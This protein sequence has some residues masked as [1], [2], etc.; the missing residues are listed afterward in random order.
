MPDQ[1]FCYIRKRWI[2]ATPEEKIRQF[3]IK[4]MVEKLQY[5]PNYFIMEKGLNQMP[6]LDK[7]CLNSL[8][9]RRIDLI[10]LAKNLHPQYPLYPLLLIECKAIKITQKAIRQV[11]GYNHFLGACFVAVINQ[12]ET[13]L[14]SSRFEANLKGEHLQEPSFP[15][16][17]TLLQKAKAIINVDVN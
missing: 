5:P 10:V 2:K 8:P 1:L 6:H 7:A 9:F 17:P 13:H 14:Y 11:M 12:V 3:L 4:Q 15:D 16:Y